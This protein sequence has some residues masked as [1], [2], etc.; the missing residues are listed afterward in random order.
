MVGD[1]VDDLIGQIQRIGAQ[2]LV[3][4]QAGQHP[5]QNQLQQGPAY[6]VVSTFCGFLQNFLQ[7]VFHIG[8]KQFR[9]QKGIGRML[10]QQDAAVYARQGGI[11]DQQGGAASRRFR[12]VGMHLVGENDSQ[13]PFFKALCLPANRHLCAAVQKIKK[14]Q[15]PVLMQG[16][17]EVFRHGSRKAVVSVLKKGKHWHLQKRNLWRNFFFIWH[18]FYHGLW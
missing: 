5:G 16:E 3:Q 7:G 11:A 15:M 4:G 13:R 6:A 12:P 1:V 10:G 2:V 8:V 9:R 18:V 17:S 14:L